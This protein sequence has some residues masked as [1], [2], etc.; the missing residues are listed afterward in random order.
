MSHWSLVMQCRTP[1]LTSECLEKVNVKKL[2]HTPPNFFKFTGGVCVTILLHF[3]MNFET[4]PKCR[5]VFRLSWNSSSIGVPILERNCFGHWDVDLWFT[6][7]RS[8]GASKM[9]SCSNLVTLMCMF[10]TAFSQQG[11]RI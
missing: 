4:I 6:L 1:A 11:F 8:M 10:A 9:A 7:L 2:T 5:E 3:F